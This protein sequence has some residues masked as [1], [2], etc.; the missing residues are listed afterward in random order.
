[1]CGTLAGRK[2]FD[3]MRRFSV[4]NTGAT[5]IE[6]ALMVGIMATA[7][8]GFSQVFDALREGFLEPTQNAVAGV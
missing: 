6:Y 7:L 3:L 8:V 2:L 5:A 4:D 1:M